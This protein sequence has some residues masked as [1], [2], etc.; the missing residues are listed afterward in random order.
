MKKYL[1]KHTS[2]IEDALKKEGVDFDWISLQRF[3]RVRISFLQHER[4]VHLLVTFFF[5]LL[6]FFS[7]LVSLLLIN[8]ID[9]AAELSNGLLIFSLA[10]FAL[11]AFY[12]WHYFI[13]EN[14]IQK[15]YR[16]D[17]EIE[18]RLKK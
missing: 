5:G 18:E 9:G 10:L 8:M 15:L 4:L 2:F 12:V 6:F 16:L 11:L 13:L 14:G 17:E 3:H 1:K 7:A